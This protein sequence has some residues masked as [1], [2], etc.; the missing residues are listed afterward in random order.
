MLK[1]NPN[2][3]PTIYQVLREA[4]LMQGI[5]VTIKDVCLCVL[6][7]EPKLM[8]TDL[9]GEDSIGVETESAITV[10]HK[11]YCIPTYRWSRFFTAC[12]AESRH[13]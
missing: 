2:S 11:G 4:C 10:A 6:L 7:P 9:C 8:N 13:T 1:E 12:T 5:E 3:R